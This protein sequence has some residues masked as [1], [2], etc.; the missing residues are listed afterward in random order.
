MS[1]F[2]V[3]ALRASERRWLAEHLELAWGSTT[4]VSRGRERDAS[5]LGVLVATAGDELVGLA[6][7][8]LD[9]DACQLVTL[10]AFRP[11]AGIGSAL[12]AAVADHARSH[13]CRRLWLVTTN[14]NLDA[15]RFYQR[16][17]MRLTAVHAGAVDAAR[18][19]K[20]EIPRTGAHG[21]RISDELELELLLR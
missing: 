16:R 9:G 12:L 2:E 8:E 17:G 4:L 1:A 19:L 20:P 10:E 3:R 13:G 14:D 5:E 7:Y 21:I 18:A 15:L 6:T 11:Q